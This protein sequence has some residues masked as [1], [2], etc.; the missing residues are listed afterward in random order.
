MRFF[1]S[2]KSFSS[3]FFSRFPERYRRVTERH[4]F[5]ITLCVCLAVITASAIWAKIPAQVEP[6][7]MAAS[8]TPDFVDRLAEV[9][10]QPTI[11]PLSPP[12]PTPVP[13]WTKPVV[14]EIIRSFSEAPVYHVTSD[15]WS[16]HTA[17]DIAVGKGETVAAPYDGRVRE[18]IQDARYGW[19]L[20][21]DMTDGSIV[22]IA[23][24]EKP[25]V[26]AG[27]SVKQGQAIGV[28]GGN[29][30]CEALDF[31]HIHI[32]WVSEGYKRDITEKW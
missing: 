20:I 21:M 12:A 15:S 31:L 16:G 13:K 26:S 24:L 19:T 18:F 1:N 2:I 6:D 8:D 14:G 22:S 5:T 3:R 29:I 25:S 28:A 9:M 7:N 32:E 27:A 10:T 4:G 30:P 11:P 17:V 23:G